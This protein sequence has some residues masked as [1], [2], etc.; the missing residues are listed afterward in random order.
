MTMRVSALVR[1]R[2]I[3]AYAVGRRPDAQGLRLINISSRE[4]SVCPAQPTTVHPWAECAAVH[5]S[6]AGGTLLTTWRKPGM[7]C[8]WGKIGI[9]PWTLVGAQPRWNARHRS[10]FASRQTAVF[11]LT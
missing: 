7:V 10:R 11:T 9:L 8:I 4:R 1:A 2:P 6:V 3:P 5:E